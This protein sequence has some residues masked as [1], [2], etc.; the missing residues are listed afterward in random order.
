MVRDVSF[1]VLCLVVDN[2]PDGPSRSETCLLRS[3]P[4][5]FSKSYL[6]E[7]RSQSPQLFYTLLLGR[8]YVRQD[9]LNRTLHSPVGLGQQNTTGRV[10]IPV[11]L[12]SGPHKS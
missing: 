6:P 12:G 10:P 3:L 5:L 8:S 4:N 9:I 1:P 7:T 11:G 2:A